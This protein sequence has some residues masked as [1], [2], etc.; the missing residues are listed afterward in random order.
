VNLKYQRGAIGNVESYQQAVYGYDVRTEIVG[1]KGAIFVGT[2]QH[3]PALFLSV[4]GGIQS[5][6]EH[7]L[8]K[9]V[10]AYL[11]E[12]RDFVHNILHDKPFRVSAEDGWKALAIAVAAEASHLQNKAVKVSDQ[13]SAA[14]S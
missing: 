10:D 6:P 9:F 13:V 5:L 1:S 4:N 8:S 12:M 14:S 3:T 11:L 2:M 7:F